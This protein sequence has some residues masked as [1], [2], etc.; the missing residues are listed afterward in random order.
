VELAALAEKFRHFGAVEAV[1][2][3]ELY[4]DLALRVAECP[5]LLR[6]VA[7]APPTQPPPNLLFAAVQ[8]IL[9]KDDRG[10]RAGDD[11][12]TAFELLRT[13]VLDRTPEI[14]RILCTR[15]VQTNEV[16]RSI[17]LYA[18]LA[19][20]CRLIPERR[21]AL[22]EIGASAGL[23]LRLD[24]YEYRFNDGPPF[25]CI[26]SRVRISSELKGS[27]RPPT[28]VASDEIVAR[29]GIDLNPIDID[30]PEEV[31]WLRALIWPEHEERRA[32]LER[33]IAFR[34]PVPVEMIAGDGVELLTPILGRI[35]PDT[36]PIVFHTHVA[37]QLSAES[38]RTLLDE[39]DRQGESRNIAHLHNNIEPSLY[40]SVFVGSKRID[41]PL[42]NVDG[43]ARWVEWL[44][45]E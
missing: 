37:N 40:A 3:S 10:I 43:H 1:G 21:I 5:E 15:L 29:I 14:E 6:V 26:G 30:N 7:N 22:I 45:A 12:A 27:N 41:T 17:Y 11:A 44:A 36:V 4:S 32:L 34:A 38:K 25:G 31:D 28:T 23:N 18:A 35:P 8:S 16:R 33:A 42:A 19:W 9:M 2:S 24:H 13:T 20:I 39:I